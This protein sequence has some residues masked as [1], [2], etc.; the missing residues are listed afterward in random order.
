M[1]KKDYLSNRMKILFVD[2]MPICCRIFMTGLSGKHSM[3]WADNVPEALDQIKKNKY[4][5][6][7][8]D[9]HLGDSFP[10]GGSNVILAAYAW[11]IPVISISSENKKYEALE[12]GANR[13]V[14]KRQFW[15]NIE[16]IIEEELQNAEQQ[17]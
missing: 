11:N 12:D 2:D 17:R 10:N 16:G 6:V 9:W 1:E 14:F 3:Y 7:I 5:L 13:F 8:T 15:S 4:D